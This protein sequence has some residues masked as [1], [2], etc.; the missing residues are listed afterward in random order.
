M[1]MIACL[2]HDGTPRSLTAKGHS[3]RLAGLAAGLPERPLEVAA[4]ARGVMSLNDLIR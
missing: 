2:S 3:M 4:A 1:A